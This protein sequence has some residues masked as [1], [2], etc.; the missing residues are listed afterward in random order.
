M[1]NLDLLII[2]KILN[3]FNNLDLLGLGWQYGAFN[4]ISILIYSY[5]TVINK[6]AKK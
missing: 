6:R 5:N 1:F 3:V 4:L 2:E